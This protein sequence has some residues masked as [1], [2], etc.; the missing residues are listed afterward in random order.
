MVWPLRMKNLIYLWR[1]PTFFCQWKYNLR[2]WISFSVKLAQNNK[3]LW[4]LCSWC[5]C[6]LCCEMQWLF[7]WP[8]NYNLE[9]FPPIYWQSLPNLVFQIVYLTGFY[10]HQS[11]T[12]HVLLFQCLSVVFSI[13]Y[14][15]TENCHIFQPENFLLKCVKFV[16]SCPRFQWHQG[17]LCL[18]SP[19]N[20]Q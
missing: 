8:K 13:F 14:V 6:L 16:Q 19:H 10:R 4:W 17:S 15:L 11:L 7:F 9:V 2:T 20:R 1:L 5:V 18:Y 3:T 12:V